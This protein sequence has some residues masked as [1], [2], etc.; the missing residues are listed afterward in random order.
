MSRKTAAIQSVKLSQNFEL[1]PCYY[2]NGQ[3]PEMV[4]DNAKVTPTLF[5]QDQPQDVAF[6]KKLLVE[7]AK[8]GPLRR[9]FVV[10]DTLL[11]TSDPAQALQEIAPLRLDA[12]TLVL[13]GDPNIY[14]TQTPALVYWD[15]TSKAFKTVTDQTQILKLVPVILNL[16]NKEGAKKP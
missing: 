14:P 13:A 5:I 11:H 8:L 4:F 3:K 15:Q 6:T 2:S 1:I 10:M 9:P 12:T 7:G 16:N